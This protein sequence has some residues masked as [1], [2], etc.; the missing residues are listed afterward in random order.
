M[1]PILHEF[2]DVYKTNFTLVDEIRSNKRREIIHV[3]RVTYLDAD[4]NSDYLV[5]STLDSAFDFISSNL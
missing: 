5:F 2:P 1:K 4:G 3:Y